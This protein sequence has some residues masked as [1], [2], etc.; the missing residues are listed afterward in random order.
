MLSRVNIPPSAAPFMVKLRTN[1]RVSMARRFG[2]DGNR[3]G[4][5]IK[6]KKKKLSF[7]KSG[8]EFRKNGTRGRGRGRKTPGRRIENGTQAYCPRDEW[9][10]EIRSA[11]SK[12]RPKYRVSGCLSFLPPPT[13]LSASPF[14]RYF[15]SLF[16]PAGQ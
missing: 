1:D 6:K 11:F 16:P 3:G 15:C 7:P 5:A 10:R 12:M 13:P 9:N 8:Y 14:A 4:Q 2:E